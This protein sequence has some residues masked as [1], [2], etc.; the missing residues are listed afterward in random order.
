VAAAVACSINTTLRD[1]Q[2]I[3]NTGLTGDF[4]SVRR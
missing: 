3:K 1:A 4:G 2:T